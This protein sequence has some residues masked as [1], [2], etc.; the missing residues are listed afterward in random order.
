MSIVWRLRVGNLPKYME[1]KGLKKILV[2]MDIEEAKVKKAPKWNYGFLT[3][4]SKATLEDAQKKLDGF[5]VRDNTLSIEN[6]NTTEDAH[7]FRFDNRAAQVREKIPIDARAAAEKLAEQVTPYYKMPYDRQLSKKTTDMAKILSDFRNKMKKMPNKQETRLK[8]ET[9]KMWLAW[10]LDN[11]LSLPFKTLDTIPSPNTEG[12]RT[13]CEFTIGF[14]LD[15]NRTVGFLLGLYKDGVTAVLEPQECVHVGDAAKKVATAMQN[16]VRSSDLEPYDRTTK[17]GYWRSLLVRT[18]RCGEIMIIVQFHPQDLTEERITEEKARIK[19]FWEAMRTAS[20]GAV[21]TTTLLVQMYN[22]IANGFQ[23]H[24]PMELMFGPGYVHE[25]MLGCRFRISP[26][27]FF[28]VNTPGAEMLYSMC[29]DWCNIDPTKST[30][31][32]DLCCGT[33]T[34]GITMANSVGKVIGVE[35]VEQSVADARENAKNNGLNNAEYICSKVEE[36]LH[37]LNQFDSLTDSVVAVLDPP[38]YAS[39]FLLLHFYVDCSD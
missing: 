14:D 8:V 18:Q 31:L 36:V 1:P 24:I 17:Q 33:G 34:I 15:G 35:M 2:K 11:S 13:K 25:D 39:S 10:S 6:C 28:Q 4:K 30:T 3:F 21:D 23:E 5:K 12:Y 26:T 16:Y 38:R 27:A 29:R 9:A 19:A 7:R 20:E 32:L 22:G 37:V